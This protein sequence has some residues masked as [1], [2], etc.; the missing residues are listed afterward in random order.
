M[1]VQRGEIRVVPETI[2]RFLFE[3]AIFA[4]LNLR[5]V[6]SL[7]HAFDLPNATPVAL[8]RYERESGWRFGPIASRYPT[9]PT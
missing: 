7:P 9:R 3:S 1:I 8:R 6:P 2:A 4:S 5:G